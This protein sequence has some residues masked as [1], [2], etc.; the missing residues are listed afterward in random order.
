MIYFI[1]ITV[2]IDIDFILFFFSDL[3][4]RFFLFKALRF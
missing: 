2:V 4:L 3:Q 1:R